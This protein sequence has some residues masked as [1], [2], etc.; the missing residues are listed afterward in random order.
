MK[1]GNNKEVVALLGLSVT[2]RRR[3]PENCEGATQEEVTLQ[4]NKGFHYRAPVSSHPLR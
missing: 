2:E 1:K 3:G 4:H